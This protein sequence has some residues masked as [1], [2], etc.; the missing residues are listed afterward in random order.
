[1]N[2]MKKFL[3]IAPVAFA[4]CAGI[5]F[6]TPGR[7]QSATQIG[8][9]RFLFIFDA[10]SEMKRRQTAVQ[11]EVTQLLATSMGGQLHA[12]DSIGVWTFGQELSTTPFPQLRWLPEDAVSIA[13]EINK[14]VGK[15]GFAGKTRFG[16]LQPR[17]N[18][19]IQG[20]GRLT[21]LIFS[22]GGDDIN[23]TP[24]D[25]GINQVFKQR[26]SE[27]KNARQP[28]VLV[29]RTQLGQYTGCTMNFPPGMVSIPEFPPLPAP[30]APPAPTNPP[31]PAPPTP[32]NPPPPAPEVK[33]PIGAPLIIIGTT[34]HTNW[35][36]EPPPPKPEPAAPT[37]VAPV[38]PT[39]IVSIAPTNAVEPPQPTIPKPTIQTNEAPAPPVNPVPPTNS[40]PAPLP[41][42]VSAT[43]P[44]P[45]A[46]TNPAASS[47]EDSGP[48]HKVALA[49]GGALL[50]AG[51]G[52]A[53]LA[54]FR[55]RRTD[56]S[57][58]ITRSMRKE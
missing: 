16:A 51:G 54:A 27:E 6:S 14:F 46:S 35:P 22:D 47:P 41:K 34:V 23:W 31:P 2:Q 26:A 55:S 4:L 28:F 20:S 37:N 49:I 15:Q 44:S 58:L 57:S 8:G 21:V 3:R 10:S 24:Y 13:S 39:N 25:P 38:M 45:T 11:A 1:M 48:T 42:P 52:L 17:L 32:T 53:V 18:Q 9:E 43:P 33:A 30:P 40:T 36:P 12:G 19:V 56:R 5:Q 50:V 7:A 29:F